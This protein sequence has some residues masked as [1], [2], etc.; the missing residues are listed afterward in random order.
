MDASPAR[1]V[2]KVLRKKHGHHKQKK[3]R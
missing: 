3:G 1:F 2:V